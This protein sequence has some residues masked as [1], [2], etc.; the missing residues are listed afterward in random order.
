[1]P[2][3]TTQVRPLGSTVLLTCQVTTPD[4]GDDETDYNLE[5]TALT[6]GVLRNINSRTGRFVLHSKC[7]QIC[8]QLDVCPPYL[9]KLFQCQETTRSLRSTD[10]LSLFVPRTRTETAKRAFSVAAPNVWNSLPIGVRNTQSVHFSKQI[11]DILFT[12]AYT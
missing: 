7:P 8:R 10:A 1:M 2:L 4:N 6:G 5:W 11:E 9:D 3:S 12:A